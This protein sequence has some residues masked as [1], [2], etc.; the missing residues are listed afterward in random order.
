MSSSN[1]WGTASPRFSQIMQNLAGEPISKAAANQVAAAQMA[2]ESSPE[3]A[4]AAEMEQGGGQPPQGGGPPME[5]QRPDVTLADQLR[6]LAEME[7]DMAKKQLILSAADSI[8]QTNRPVTMDQGAGQ[9]IPAEGEQAPAGSVMDERPP[10]AA[11]GKAASASEDDSFADVAWTNPVG[12]G[13][14]E[15]YAT[16]ISEDDFLGFL[17]R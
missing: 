4:A 2:N 16:E 15:K 7:P 8:D 6:Q 5:M 10:G 17:R 12:T 14:H 1:R 9:E 11:M 13:M 3:E